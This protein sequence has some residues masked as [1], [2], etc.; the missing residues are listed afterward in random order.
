MMDTKCGCTMC[1]EDTCGD[2]LKA[3]ESCGRLADME[4]VDVDTFSHFY[5]MITDWWETEGRPVV[6][7]A[8]GQL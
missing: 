5:T 8:R 1:L 7:R 3:L 6:E 2:M 4:V